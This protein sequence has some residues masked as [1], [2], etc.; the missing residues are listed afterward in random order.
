MPA[1]I[2]NKIAGCPSMCGRRLFIQKVVITF[3]IVITE[4]VGFARAFAADES[5]VEAGDTGQHLV[6]CCELL[7][8][9]SDAKLPHYDQHH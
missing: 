2:S 8:C 9:G 6:M 7:G 3:C 1:V 4:W 5:I